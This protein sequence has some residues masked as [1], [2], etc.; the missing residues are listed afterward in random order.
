MKK[1]KQLSVVAASAILIGNVAY[2]DFGDAVVGGVVGGAVGSVITNEVYNKNRQQTTQPRRADTPRQRYHVP[3][4]T[5]EKRIQRS[6]SSLGF[7][8]GRIDGQINSYET[9]AAIKEM[10]IGYEIGSSAS[11]KP[12]AKDTLIF[13]GT[14]FEFDRYLNAQSNDRRTR[15]KKIQVALK[16]HGYYQGKIDGLIGRGSRGAIAQYKADNRMGYSGSLDFEQEYQLVSSAKKKN[17][18]NIEEAIASL[19][20]LG[21]TATPKQNKVIEV[22]QSSQLSVE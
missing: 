7:Y 19:K 20:A 10:N 15:N 21:K 22:Q 11:L 5:D 16:L 4:M 12:E 13:L 18:R 14:L 2:A 3:K 1:I 6:L 9:R 17:D 8:R